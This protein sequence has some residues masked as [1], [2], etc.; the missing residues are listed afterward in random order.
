MLEADRRGFF[1]C[2]YWY[3]VFTENVERW[4]ILRPYEVEKADKVTLMSVSQSSLTSVVGG[5]GGSWLQVRT[6]VKRDTIRPL[7]A[8]QIECSC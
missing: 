7:R 1:L 3:S 4:V 8:Y 6:T 2:Q 5:G